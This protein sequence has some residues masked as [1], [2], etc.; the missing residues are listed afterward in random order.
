MNPVFLDE[1]F[2]L[3]PEGTE[4]PEERVWDGYHPGAWRGS[5]CTAP[6]GCFQDASTKDTFF[7]K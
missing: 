1:S 7:V 6:R 5:P 4:H 2:G 3:R